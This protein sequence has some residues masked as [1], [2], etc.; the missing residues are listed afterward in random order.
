[1]FKMCLQDF[2]GQS[3]WEEEDKRTGTKE[4]TVRRCPATSRSS[5]H[6]RDLSAELKKLKGA[7][8]F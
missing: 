7:L 4:F 6:K 5:V 8:D 2:Y 3:I 1:M